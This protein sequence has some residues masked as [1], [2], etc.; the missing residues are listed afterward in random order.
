MG[1]GANNDIP[2]NNMINNNTL[3]WGKDNNEFNIWNTWCIENRDL[4]FINNEG[5]IAYSVN[6]TQEFNES[7]IISNI[8]SLLD[9]Q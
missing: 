6:L 3:P 8:N 2:V 5:E 4:L 9:S 7:I 1:I